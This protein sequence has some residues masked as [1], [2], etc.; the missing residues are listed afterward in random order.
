M[1][2]M[3]STLAK[4]S[5]FLLL[6]LGPLIA[7]EPALAI[8]GFA[9]RYKLACQY[10]H[11]GMPK[12][13]AEGRAFKERG[14]RLE[15]DTFEIKE[16]LMTLPGTIRA[17]VNTDRVEEEEW[18]TRAFYKVV[19]AGSLWPRVSFWADRNF[20][21]TEEDR[22]ID[23]GTDNAYL[24]FE[25]LP[26]KLYARGG[27]IELDLPFTQARS[28][29]LFAYDIYF[30][31]TGFE[32]DAIGLHQSGVELGGVWGEKMRWSVAVVKGQNSREARRLSD[33][34]DRFDGNVFGRL[35]RQ[36]GAHRFGALV[37][38]GRNV[39]SRF[40]GG[41]RI[42]WDDKLLRLGIDWDVWWKKLN[43]YGVLMHAGN[44]NSIADVSRPNG[45]EAARTVKGGF[46]Q[47]DYHMRDWLVLTVQ[48][49]LIRRPRTIFGPPDDRETALGLAPGI[50]IWYRERIKLTI[51]VG[52]FNL[53]RPA[54]AIFQAEVAL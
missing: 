51:E 44:S 36:Q 32:S 31:N 40:D 1:K 4:A 20:A 14:F 39:L 13:S 54:I 23:A 22:T 16:W 28:P 27:R 8:P 6:L 38:L 9:R 52:L 15:N 41:E 33:R 48:G 53:N 21:S 5:G 24:R 7:A 30:A 45:T 19:V 29:H 49:N 17:G 34:A 11:E 3:S 47:T 35:V 46:L 50:E 25:I 10:C 43:V 2:T 37:Y 18:S 12:L 42:E 26:G